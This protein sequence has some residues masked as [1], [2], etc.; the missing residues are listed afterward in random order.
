M[1]QQE[2]LDYLKQRPNQWFTCEELSQVI[3]GVPKCSGIIIGL[4][5]MRHYN[6]VEFKQ[7]YIT[8]EFKRGKKMK[9]KLYL[10]KYKDYE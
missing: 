6:E 8:K 10:Y 4:G 9:F 3:F 7:D 1:T 5:Q 2:I